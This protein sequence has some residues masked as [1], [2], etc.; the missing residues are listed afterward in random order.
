MVDGAAQLTDHKGVTR[1][2][3]NGEILTYGRVRIEV[4]GKGS[5]ADGKPGHTPPPPRA[6][7]EKPKTTAATSKS[8]SKAWYS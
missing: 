3:D 2:L 5:K 4:C 8:K 7:P 1:V 6:I